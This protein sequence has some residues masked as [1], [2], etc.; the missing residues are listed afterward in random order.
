MLYAP[1]FIDVLEAQQIKLGAKIQSGSQAVV[2][3]ITDSLHSLPY[4]SITPTE[5][6]PGFNRSSRLRG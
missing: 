2:T 4:S 1:K 6:V 5:Q 3:A